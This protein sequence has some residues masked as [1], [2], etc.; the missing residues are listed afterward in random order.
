MTVLS[1]RQANAKKLA[2]VQKNRV[3]L[4]KYFIPSKRTLNYV[5][6]TNTWAGQYRKK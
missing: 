4:W 2:V 1:L 3:K 5:I 6:R